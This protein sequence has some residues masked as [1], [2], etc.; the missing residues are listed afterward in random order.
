MKTVTKYFMIAGTMLALN[1]ACSLEEY[2]PSGLTVD[3]VLE[4]YDGYNKLINNCYFDI[5]R[6]FY[7]RSLLLVTEAGTDIW[8][9]DQNST[10]NQQYFKYASGGAMPVDMAKIFG[11]VLTMGSTRAM[12]VSIRIDK[13]KV[14]L[15]SCQKRKR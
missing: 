7:G 14:F 15:R 2:N 6:Y 8:T 3:M 5:P 12:H 4:T 13:V 9:A 11:T 10:N 1:S